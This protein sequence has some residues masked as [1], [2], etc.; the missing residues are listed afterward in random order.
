MQRCSKF[1]FQSKILEKKILFIIFSVVLISISPQVFAEDDLDVLLAEKNAVLI[2]QQKIIFEVGKH[3]EVQVKHVIET[4]AWG[5]D[6]PRVIEVISGAHSNLTVVDEDDY[7]LSSSYDAETFEDSKY[8]ILNQKLGNYDLIAEYTLYNFMELK[9]GLWAKELK[10]GDGVTV[11]IEDDIELIFANSR[12]IDLSDANGINC[13]GCNML[14]EYFDAE[15]F[16]SKEVLSSNDKFTIDFLSNGEFSEMEFITGGTQLLNFDVTNEDQ[17][18]VM[19]IP[20]EYLL[21]PYDIY[22]TENDDT[23]LDQ[24]DKIR[25]TEFSQDETHVNVS[26]RTFGEGTVSIV[27]A[28]SEEH[29][30]KLEQIEN[31]KAREVKSQVIEEEKGLA[32]PIPGTKAASELAA[33]SGQMNEEMVDKLSFADELEKGPVQNSDDNTIIVTI[34]A[35]IIIA[36]IIGGVIFKLKKN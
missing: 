24:I 15:K 25:K 17:L 27:G 11:M 14:L 5:A 28:T 8:I 29:Q 36:G 4:G 22:F 6:R 13:I 30:K 7:R 3:A 35:G 16:S 1:Q 12:P 26:F 34:V 10:F 31:I 32:L 21:N 2:E 18:F 9:N 19:K 23:N 33:K 20:F